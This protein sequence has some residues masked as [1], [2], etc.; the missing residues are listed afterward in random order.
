LVQDWIINQ[1][2]P[3]TE[4][5]RQKGRVAQRHTEEGDGIRRKGLLSPLSLTFCYLS[6]PAIGGDDR[7]RHDHGRDRDQRKESFLYQYL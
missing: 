7:D 4:L 3:T 2:C 6:L 5:V 1:I